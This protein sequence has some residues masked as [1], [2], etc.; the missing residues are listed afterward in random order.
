MSMHNMLR[1]LQEALL[2]NDQQMADY[3]SISVSQVREA[4]SEAGQELPI[5]AKADIL[6]T[7]GFV[8]ITDAAMLLLT[9]KQREKLEAARA[10]RALSIAQNKSLKALQKQLKAREKDD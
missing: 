1:Q 4:K 5:H 7:L 9:K 10:S 6:D 2:L 8:K 3:L